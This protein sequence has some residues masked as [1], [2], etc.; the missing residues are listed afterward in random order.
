MDAADVHN[1]IQPTASLTRSNVWFDDG[2]VVLQAEATLFRVYRGVLA[3]QSPIFRDTFTI[4]QPVEQDMYD[5]YPQLI[6]HDTADDLKIFLLALHDAGYFMNSPVDGIKTLSSLLKLATKYEVGHLR[7]R[8]IFIL[9]RLYPSSRTPLLWVLDRGSPSGYTRRGGD[10]FIALNLATEYHVAWI[11]PNIYYACCRHSIAQFFDAP[12]PTAEKTR[13]MKAMKKFSHHWRSRIYAG[14]Y[15][16]S[17]ACENER[18]CQTA[19]LNWLRTNT[20]LPM[21]GVF[22]THSFDWTKVGLCTR[23]TITSKTD[24]SRERGA[25]WT[26]L[27]TLFG[28]PSWD[29]L[30]VLKARQ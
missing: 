17:E 24:Y 30:L 6:V 19:R 27:P 5:G 22:S 10:D 3:A 20:N 28:L 14:V 12:I 21:S 2:T 11:L 18:K 25:L 26:A 23:C 15:T 9:A 16:G 4:P 7:T 8:M 13:C 29:E 1:A